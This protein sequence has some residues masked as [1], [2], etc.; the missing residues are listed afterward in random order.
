MEE[1]NS[2]PFKMALTYGIYMAI[3]SIIVTLVVWAT[4][5]IETLGL[6]GSSIIAFINLII[7]VTLLVIFTKLY[8]DN[9][10]EGKITFGKAFTFGLLIVICSSLITGVFSYI[11]YKFIDPGYMERIMTVVQEKT[12]QILA[13]KGLS[14]DQIDAAMRAFEEKGVPT[15]MQSVQSALLNGIIGGSIMSLISSAIVKK[16]TQKEDAFEEA[17]DEVKNDE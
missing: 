10:L 4:S 14:E 13:N 12:Y 9:L 15:P 5:L 11:L 6:M 2:S 8:R 7:T 1:N 17:M 3:I 16:N